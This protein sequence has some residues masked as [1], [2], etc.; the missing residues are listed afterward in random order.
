MPTDSCSL[1]IAGTSL[2][3]MPSCASDCFC[4][5]KMPPAT[6]AAVEAKTSAGSAFSTISSLSTMAMPMMTAATAA[7]SAI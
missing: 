7:T 1:V 3:M 5:A 2:A 4:T 6:A